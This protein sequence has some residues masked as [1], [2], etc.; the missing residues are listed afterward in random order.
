[1]TRTD[2]TT[3]TQGLRDLATALDADPSL[4]L[5]YHGTTSAITF[6]IHDDLEQALRLRVLMTNPVTSHDTS[7]TFPVDIGGH[8][9]GL[10]VAV[11]IAANLALA[12]NAIDNGPRWP[13]T[14]PRLGLH[15]DH[16]QVAS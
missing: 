1:M 16:D 6:F 3:Y 4:P 8:L 10:P 11:H 12:A 5:P 14:D 15:S 7:A 2:R 13:T 9:Y